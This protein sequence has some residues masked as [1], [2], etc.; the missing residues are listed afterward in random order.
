MA[1]VKQ[2]G[3]FFVTRSVCRGLWAKEPRHSENTLAETCHLF[4]RMRLTQW[5]NS[6]TSVTGRTAVI[7]THGTH[8]NLSIAVFVYQTYCIWF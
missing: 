6:S 5:Y 3:S 2:N 7:R 4:S 8:K 1:R